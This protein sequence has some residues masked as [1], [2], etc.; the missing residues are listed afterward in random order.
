MGL[1]VSCQRFEL[2][3]ALAGFCQP[4][5][6]DNPFVVAEQYDLEQDRWIVRQTT[7]LIILITRLE[8]THVDVL[9]DNFIEG[10]FETTGKNLVLERNGNQRDLLYIVRLVA[11]H[12]WKVSSVEGCRPTVAQFLP[13]KVNFFYSLNASASALMSSEPKA[14]SK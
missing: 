11:S 5:A 7:R 14:V 12:L 2:H 1:A 13:P 8:W 9:I 4:A 10:V 6:R 3:V